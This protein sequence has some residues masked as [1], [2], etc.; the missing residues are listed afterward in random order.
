[1]QS[2]DRANA[3]HAVLTTE[4]GLALLAEVAKV[5]EPRP[6][7]LTRWRT[8]AP[9]EQVAAAVRMAAC[10][11]RGAA[12]FRLADRMWLDAVGLEQATAEAV[13]LHKARRFQ[14]ATVVDLCSGIGGD[15]LAMAAESRVV[16][17]DL[18][19]ALPR[20][21]RWNAEV[22]GVADRLLAVRARAETF[23]ILGNALVH[24][25]PDRRAGLKPRAQFVCDYIPEIGILKSL[26]SSNPGGALKLGPASDFEAQFDGPGVEIELISLGGECKEATVWFGS[27]ASA[28][29]RATCLPSGATWTDADGIA[30]PVVK[31]VSAWVFDPDPALVRAGLLDGFADAHGLAR[32][33]DGIDLLT[34]PTLVDSPWLSAF[35]VRDVIP[36]DL[37]RLRRLVAELGLGPLEIKTRRLPSLRPDDLRRRL[38]PQGVHPATLLLHGGPGPA[39]AIVAHRVGR[40]DGSPCSL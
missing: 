23:S 24:V 12:K 36:L 6:A 14:G 34:G 33:A 18:D 1:M 29:R 31:A 39:R 15:A 27:L 5:A 40:S 37:K 26:M 13:A 32:L 8:H 17:V 20:R 7:D 2:L 28:R 35:E 38:H 21:L 3:E 9:A 25:D 16:A 22:H 19:P 11:R 4:A 10:R 30:G